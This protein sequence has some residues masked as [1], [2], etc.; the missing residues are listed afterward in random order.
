MQKAQNMTDHIFEIPVLLV[1]FNRPLNAKKVF[2]VIR[3]VRPAKFY[4][5]S[6]APRPGNENDQVNVKECRELIKLIDWECDVKTKFEKVNLGCG[7]GPMSAITWMFQHEEKGIILEDDCLPDISFFSYCR[8][9]LDRYEHQPRVMHVAGT[10][11]NDEYKVDDSDHFFSTIGHIWGWATWRRA[12]QLYDYEMKSWDKTKGRKL[13]KSRLNNRLLS[14]FWVDSFEYTYRNNPRLRHA[15][16]YQWQYTLFQHNGLSVVPNVNLV[17]NIGVQGV[18]S[19]ED[20]ADKTSFNRHTSPWMN[21]KQQLKII[22]QHD[23]DLYH[24]RN[25]FMRDVKAVR[26][27]KLLIKSFL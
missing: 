2:D 3:Q 25:F 27:M 6:D 1:T 23:F 20:D 19:S 21:Q 7:P 17:S 11:W 4:L 14:E 9:M 10:R 22:P 18:H 13:I 5:F 26:K 24:I 12:W 16:D 8:Y 15:W